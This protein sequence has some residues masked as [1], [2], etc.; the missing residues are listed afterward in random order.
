VR[1]VVVDVEKKA[2]SPMRQIAL[3][4]ILA[5]LVA[6]CGG[7][8]GRSASVPAS[9]AKSAL[10]VPMTFNIDVPKLT[11]AA[12][13]RHP[14]FI[15]P[16]T[17]QMLID[18]KQGTTSVSGFPTT[19]PLTTTS[20]G[21]TSTLL[22][23]SCQLTIP[24]GPGTYTAT[25]TTEDANGKAISSAQS[26]AFTVLLGANNSLSLTLSGIPH[27]I[28]VASTAAAVHGSQNEGFQVFG[29]TPQPF[30]VTARDVDG[31][32]IVGP[33]APAFAVSVV[34]GSAW[35]AAAPSVAVPNVFTITPPVN[36]LALSLHVTATYGDATCTLPGAVCATT[37][38]VKGH[39][40]EFLLVGNGGNV[41]PGA[42]LVYAA[43][44]TGTPT[45]VNNPAAFP[46]GMAMDSSGN[47]FVSNADNVTVFAP[48]YT[49]TPQTIQTGAGS[50]PAAL[51][52]DAAGN[53]FVANEHANTVAI[54]QPPY[55][56]AP[57]N[58]SN[59]V[60]V[61]FALALDGAGNLFVLN[62]GTS[63]TNGSVTIYAPPY[64]GTPITIGTGPGNQT[65]GLV[66]D[67]AA[68]VFVSTFSTN[69]VS[70]YAPPYTG[71]PKAI[72]TGLRSPGALALDASG[73]LFVA[74]GAKPNSVTVYAPPYTGA[75]SA[76]ITA[77]L[78]APD[79]LAVDRAGTLYVANFFG[80]TV[81]E[82]APPYTGAATTLTN[83]TQPGVLKY[84]FM[85]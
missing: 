10:T 65:V 25:L 18:V 39:A 34:S 41:P 49:G 70:E 59:G 37:I 5:V 67:A 31:N 45:T 76:T 17:A 66:V 7:G 75:P 9:P 32:I 36:A 1:R 68:D 44:F 27:E 71:T 20:G 51:V 40:I 35:T 80:N 29:I 33:G 13:S 15:S 81:T 84:V 83:V 58:I 57:Q 52:V 53:L 72:T 28:D 74:N 48:P 69:T 73:N 47:L 26:V 46:G 54:Y 78:N 82:Y 50:V 14:Q 23:T 3:L 77:G 24:L 60:N 38:S 4:A 61:P 55:T 42:E 11:G 79:A 63:T 19:V 43:P 62:L 12:H 56:G 16:A 2:A 22:S 64:S 30:V 21:C 8:G 6:G 85:P